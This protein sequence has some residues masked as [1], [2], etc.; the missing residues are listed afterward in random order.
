MN[1]EPPIIRGTLKQ[2]LNMRGCADTATLNEK[3]LIERCKLVG[4]KTLTGVEQTYAPDD[5]FAIVPS[6]YSCERHKFRYRSI[7]SLL[8][9]TK[10][11]KIF[12]YDEVVLGKKLVARFIWGV[13]N[14]SSD[15]HVA[16]TD[17]SNIFI[18]KSV[19]ILPVDTPHVTSAQW[20]ADAVLSYA[21]QVP[22]SR[23][24][25]Y[26]KWDAPKYIRLLEQFK[27][28]GMEESEK[29]WEPIVF[30]IDISDPGFSILPPELVAQFKLIYRS[31]LAEMGVPTNAQIGEFVEE[32]K[33]RW[34]EFFTTQVFVARVASIFWK[35]VYQVFDNSGF[36]E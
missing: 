16:G 2:L 12:Y 36:L 17:L 11:R 21:A 1:T 15:A 5:E 31:V 23:V 35:K 8:E 30:N 4:V 20:F 19:S 33:C 29:K 3:L 24:L 13:T 32:V 10:N 34:Y 26:N 7:L 27:P 9:I 18:F 14:S 28:V 6:S 22:E 25:L